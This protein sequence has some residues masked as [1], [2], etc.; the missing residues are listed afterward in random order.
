MLSPD[1]FDWMH[2]RLQQRKSHRLLHL[3][4]RANLA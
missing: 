3:A 1:V 4:D 2:R